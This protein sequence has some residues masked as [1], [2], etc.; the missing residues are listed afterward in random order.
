MHNAQE[1]TMQPQ[2]LTVHTYSDIKLTIGLQ[3]PLD[4]SVESSG[5]LMSRWNCLFSR[6]RLLDQSF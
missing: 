3:E 1:I 4:F 2:T 6:L 5:M